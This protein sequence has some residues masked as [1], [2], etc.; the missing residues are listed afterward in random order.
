MLIIGKTV[1][2]LGSGVI[3]ENSLYYL[4]NF[5]VNP[6]LFQKY[7]LQRKVKKKKKKMNICVILTY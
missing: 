2:K 1:C 6:K 7:S 3:Y 5:S 4:L